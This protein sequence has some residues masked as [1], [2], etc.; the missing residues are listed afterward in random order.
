MAVDGQVVLFVNFVQQRLKLGLIRHGARGIQL[1]Q[2]V[3]VARLGADTHAVEAVNALIA[4][5]LAVDLHARH[6][7]NARLRGEILQIVISMVGDGDKIIAR[8]AV[9]A[10]QHLRRVAS[11]RARGVGVQPALE[12]RVSLVD[13]S[14]LTYHLSDRP[15]ICMVRSTPLERVSKRKIRKFEWIFR[16]FK[17]EIR[18]L[19]SAKLRIDDAEMAKKTPKLRIREFLRHALIYHHSAHL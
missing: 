11:V 12:H 19:S 10:Q 2:S 7:E 8:G 6:D 4:G 3:A 18:R 16:Q 17:K 15:F 5:D 9:F 13:K 14:L 1:V